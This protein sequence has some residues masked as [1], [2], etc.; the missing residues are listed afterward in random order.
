[1]TCWQAFSRCSRVRVDP[2][3]VIQVYDSG[4]ATA[5]PSP[6]TA[7]PLQDRESEPER[8]SNRSKPP[9][10][11]PRVSERHGPQHDAHT[12]GSP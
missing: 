10:R 6:V 1:M 7:E 2:G 11:A 8:G 9:P 3:A 12:A 4:V 5:R